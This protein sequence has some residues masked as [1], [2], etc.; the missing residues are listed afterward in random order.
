M[1]MRF[2]RFSALATL[3]LIGWVATSTVAAPI[4][5]GNTNGSSPGFFSWQNG[6]NDTGLFG[7]PVPIGNQLVFFPSNFKAES[8]NGI[9]H[10]VGDKI[11]VDIL[12]EGNLLITQINIYE[13]GDYGISPTG[14]NTQVRAIG[15]LIV[16]PLVSNPGA[17][18]GVDGMDFNP[19]MPITSGAGVWTGNASVGYS[20]ANGVKKIHLLLDNQ[21]QA[22][23]D[24]SP[25]TNSFIEKKTAGII[26]EIIPEPATIGMLL[27][28]APLLLRR[29]RCH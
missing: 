13:I 4:P 18:V 26:I 29:R 10:Q 20:V 8:S 5:W 17:G 23:S 3:C 21:L 14:P 19:V 25:G 27:C 6:S 24:A 16:T 15:T 11:N 7:D 12:A 2:A 1:K 9:A 28:G 22:S